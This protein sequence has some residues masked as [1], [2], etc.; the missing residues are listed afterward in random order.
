MQSEFPTIDFRKLDPVFP[1]KDGKYAYTQ[2]AIEGRGAD[3]LRW[4]YNRPEKA[5]AVVCHAGFLRVGL[6]HHHFMNA[7]Y[8]IYEFKTELKDGEEWLDEWSET[9]QSVE[10]IYVDRAGEE[11]SGALSGGLK[12]SWAGFVSTDLTTDFIGP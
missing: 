5:I 11:H 9:S 2:A 6:V 8:R 1:S 3:F 4:A 12:K 7:D 10:R